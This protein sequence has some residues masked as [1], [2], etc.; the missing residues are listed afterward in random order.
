M[1]EAAFSRSG[2]AHVPEMTLASL[3]AYF[4]CYAGS[5]RYASQTC[6]IKA[7]NRSVR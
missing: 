2:A 6:S 5:S 7:K 1:D 4:A 3:V